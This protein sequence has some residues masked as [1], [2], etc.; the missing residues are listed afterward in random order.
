MK[1]DRRPGEIDHHDHGEEL[2]D[3]RLA[4]VENIDIGVGQH[5]GNPGNDADAVGAD[6]GDDGAPALR[7][8]SLFCLFRHIEK[9]AVDTSAA[10]IAVWQ[11]PRYPNTRRRG[12]RPYFASWKMMPSVWRF[13]ERTRLTPWRKSTR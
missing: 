10:A 2:A 4:D 11:V 5:V 12:G 9:P 8:G 6:D 7:G 13:P 1:R 3:H